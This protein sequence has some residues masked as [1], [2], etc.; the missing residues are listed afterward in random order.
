MRKYFLAIGL[1]VALTFLIL[2]TKKSFSEEQLQ[3]KAL[4]ETSYVNGLQNE[5]DTLKIDAGFHPQFVMI[6]RNSEEELWHYPIE[7][8]RKSKIEHKAKG[9]LPLTENQKVSA[10][11]ESIDIE[12]DVAMVKLRYFE[13]G[14]H[15]YTDFIS[16]YKIKG[17]WKIISK[18]FTKIEA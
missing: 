9:E 10:E 13:G 7:D 14:K 11:F 1:L 6:G 16:L 5:G 12:D 2:E 15:T 17:K 18:V 4:I 3:I 8:W